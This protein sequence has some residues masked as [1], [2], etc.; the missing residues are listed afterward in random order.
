[1]KN[2]LL[3][4]LLSLV[5]VYSF[6]QGF[7]K[8]TKSSNPTETVTINIDGK[9]FQ[10]GKT[11]TGNLWVKRVSQKSGKEYKM[12]LGKPTGKFFTEN[13]KK[14][15]V[16]EKNHRDGSKSYYYYTLAKSGY[17]S[18]HKLVKE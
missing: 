14:Y 17:P 9:T 6:G 3:V 12:Y 15:E 5:S 10:A 4:I 2:V 13:S 1:M 18:S 7:S 11:S 8:P 16:Y